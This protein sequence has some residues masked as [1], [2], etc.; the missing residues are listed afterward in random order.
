M[1]L[2]R[3]ARL[4]ELG[5]ERRRRYAHLAQR[6]AEHAHPVRVVEPPLYGGD[7][8]DHKQTCSWIQYKDP[9]TVPEEI[10][11]RAGRIKP[12]VFGSIAH[13]APDD[14]VRTGFVGGG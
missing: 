8:P 4:D 9:T 1:A 11:T 7:T 12:D 10:Y 5:Q 3:A 2:R 13:S 14:T 6:I